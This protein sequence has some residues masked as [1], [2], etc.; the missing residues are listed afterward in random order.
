MFELDLMPDITKQL[1]SIRTMTATAVCNVGSNEMIDG[2]TTSF[3][4]SDTDANQI[5]PI[6]CGN[7]IPAVVI[8]QV[9]AAHN[10]LKLNPALEDLAL[11]LSI[12]DATQ[13]AKGIIMALPADM[14]DVDL[15]PGL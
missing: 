13:I 11:P 10:V 9:M 5:T 2:L 15:G 7:G 4:T 8:A 12:P 3:I 6:I 14:I 1:D